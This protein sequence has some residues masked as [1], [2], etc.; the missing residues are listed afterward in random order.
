MEDM[1][2]FADNEF[3]LLEMRWLKKWYV[4]YYWRIGKHSV[5]TCPLS[6]D[7]PMERSCL[8]DIVINFNLSASQDRLYSSNLYTRPSSLSSLSSHAMHTPVY[9]YI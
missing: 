1:I 9:V 4:A 5:I 2:L 8:F 6:F 7:R 3:H